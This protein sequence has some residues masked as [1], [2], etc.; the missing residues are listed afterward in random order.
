MSAATRLSPIS[1][2]RLR[3]LIADDERDAV[4]TLA[5]LLSDEGHQVREIYRGDAVVNHVVDFKPDVVL[6]DIGMPGL[7]GYDVA[8][9]LRDLYGDKCPVLIAVTAWVT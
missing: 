5:A 8:K 4:A 2:P 6:L 9:S 3:I 7:N 1:S